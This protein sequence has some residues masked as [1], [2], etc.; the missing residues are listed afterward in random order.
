MLQCPLEGETVMQCSFEGYYCLLQAFNWLL[1]CFFSCCVVTKR[2]N[3]LNLLNYSDRTAKW[4][5]L[6]KL[7]GTFPLIYISTIRQNC[8]AKIRGTIAQYFHKRDFLFCTV[9]RTR[10]VK[11]LIVFKL[12]CVFQKYGTLVNIWWLISA[13]F[14]L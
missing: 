9:A 3:L 8:S 11:Y 2:K 13:N 12:C 10:S 14:Y 4:H 6:I 5:Q 7:Q 1:S